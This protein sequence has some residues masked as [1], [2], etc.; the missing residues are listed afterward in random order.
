MS[1]VSLTDLARMK[2]AGEKIVVVTAYDAPSARLA[3]AGGVD[4]ILV[5]DSAAM[6]VLGHDSTLPITIDE[7]IMLAR[8]ARRGAAR[9]LV[10]VDMPF[11]SFQVSDDLA[12]ENAVR[13]VKET[14]A[15][16]VKLEG[17]GASLTRA[18]AIV[19]AGIPVMGHIGL[20]PQ[21]ATLVGGYKAQGRSAAK[22]DRLV[23]DAIALQGAGCFSIVLEAMPEPVARRIT[24]S[25]QIPTI[26]IGAGAACDGQVLVWH[27][28]LGLSVGHTPQFVKRYVEAGDLIRAALERYVADVRGGRFPELR[29][30][31]S[32]APGELEQFERQV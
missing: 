26:G 24:E 6:T 4:C 13:L 2:R 16:A 27:D 30:T 9:P 7:M 14:G 21:S 18:A 11:G 10:V 12:V 15:D 20:T 3:E 29:H 19:E 17:A 32:M 8:A 23:N 5:G 25:V 1:K 22:A 28:L 31:Y